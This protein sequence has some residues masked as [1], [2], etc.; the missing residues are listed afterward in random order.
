MPGGG[1]L[2]VPSAPLRGV[3]AHRLLRLVTIAACAQARRRGRAPDHPELRTGRGL[4]LE[5]RDRGAVGGTGAG[6]AGLSPRRPAGTRTGR[7]GAARLGAT[8]A[9]AS[10][11]GRPGRTPALPPE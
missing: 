6:S 3:R 2:V 10:E 4:V 1:R 8:S 7:A 5:L 9:L 11:R